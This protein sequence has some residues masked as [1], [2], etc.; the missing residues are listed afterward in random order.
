[1][2]K[3]YNEAED[4]RQ[5]LEAQN[6]KIAILEGEKKALSDLVASLTYQL[7]IIRSVLLWPTLK[8]RP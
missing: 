6:D 7:N 8:D 4:Y 5:M 2:S 3:K 1:M